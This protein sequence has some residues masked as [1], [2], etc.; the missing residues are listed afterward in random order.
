MIEARKQEQENKNATINWKKALGLGVVA[1][2]A[3]T[4]GV[5]FGLKKAKKNFNKDTGCVDINI[6][7]NFKSFKDLDIPVFETAHI[8]ELWQQDD[9]VLGIMHDIC[10]QDL[11][12]FGEELKEKIPELA[13]MDY[14]HFPTIGFTKCNAD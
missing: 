1:T 12:K 5:I 13:D 2:A 14:V 9:D 8:D 10:F 4:G 11:G 7:S 6:T 3:I